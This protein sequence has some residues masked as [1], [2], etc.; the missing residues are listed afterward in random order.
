LYDV[1]VMENQHISAMITNGLLAEI[2]FRNIPNFKNISANFR[3]LAYDPGNK[4]SIPYTWGTTGL[5]I[6][7]DLVEKPVTR[8]ADLWDPRYAGEIGMWTMRREVISI[9]LKSLGY[10][11]NSENP[12]ELET[13][14]AHLLELRP[15]AIWVGNDAETIAP[16]LL[17]GEAVIAMGWAYDAQTGQEENEAITYLLPKEGP[18]L[19]GDNLVIPANSPHK[20]AAE[21]FLNFILQPEISAQIVNESYY[22][23]PNVAAYPF[24]NPEILNDPITYPSNEDLQNAELLLPLSPEGERLY[25]EIWERFMAVV[26]QK[27]TAR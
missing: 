24:I 20:S 13:A 16:L 10:S 5:V 1:V 4:H 2:D 17:D 21:L 6:R 7:S 19:W 22:S 3:D 14:L 11:I 12:A 8:W 23:T 27:E 18:I 9:A 26:D 25:N 15:N